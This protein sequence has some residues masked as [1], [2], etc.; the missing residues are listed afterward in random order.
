M[1]TRVCTSGD[2]APLSEHQRGPGKK[3]LYEYLMTG[4]KI[5]PIVK[6]KHR[7]IAVKEAKFRV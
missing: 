2:L 1:G 6:Q 7:D 4:D 5:F 3:V